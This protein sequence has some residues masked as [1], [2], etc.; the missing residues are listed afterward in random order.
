LIDPQL[1]AAIR[2]GEAINAG[3]GLPPRDAEGARA[4]AARTRAWLNEGGPQLAES[5]EDHIPGPFRAIPGM[6]YRPARE[7]ALP[8]FVY[9]HGGGFRVGSHKSNDRQMREIAAAWGGAVVNADYVHTPEHVFPDPVLEAAAV[10][11][12]LAA[13]GATWGIDGSRMVFG[14][15][16]AGAN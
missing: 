8:V 2:R 11:R 3:L 7:A 4:H 6:V 10:Y 15:S 1:A 5:R 9:F 16:S 13:N 14:G 12:W